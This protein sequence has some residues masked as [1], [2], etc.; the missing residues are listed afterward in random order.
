MTKKSIF[1]N[2]FFFNFLS[3]SDV[4]KVADYEYDDLKLTGLTVPP[5][6]IQKRSKYAIF[7]TCVFI[8][9]VKFAIKSRTP[10]T[11]MIFVSRAKTSWR[12]ERDS[13]LATDR[14][15]HTWWMWPCEPL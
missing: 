5:I 3:F 13:R 12:T 8:N 6:H 7:E 14:A 15:Q 1:Q 9:L 10:I 11:N 2:N 4:T